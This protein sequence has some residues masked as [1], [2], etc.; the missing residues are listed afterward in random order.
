MAFVLKISNGNTTADFIDKLV[1]FNVTE[2]GL[3]L[4]QPKAKGIDSSPL[5]GYHGK[6]FSYVEYSNRKVSL[7]FTAYGT[8]Y[9]A[10]MDNLNTVSKLINEGNTGGLVDLEVAVQ[11][12]NSSYLRI[13]SGELKLPEQL[14]SMSGAHWTE[15]DTYVLHN[16]V[17]TVDTAPFF[18]DY[19]SY[20]KE[21]DVSRLVTT[22]I[23]NGDVISIND[24]D[25]DV[26]TETVLE[27]VGK[28][29]N[30]TQKIYI[31]NGNF[32]YVTSLSAG[33]DGSVTEM[34]VDEDYT[35][36]VLVPFA[37]TID[38]EDL[39]VTDIEAGVWTIVRG[40]NA[41]SP[42]THSSA[43]TVTLNTLHHL[44]AD[45]SL[46]YCD[47]SN[48]RV[49]VV[50]SISINTN[51]TGYIV[52]EI[53][54]FT[55][56]SGNDDCKIRILS[57]TATGA[58]S[59]WEVK[60]GGSDYTASDTNV[61]VSNGVAT[62]DIDEITDVHERGTV[63]TVSVPGGSSGTGYVQDEDLA[64]NGGDGNLTL[65]ID[66]VGG[67]GEVLTVSILTDGA[68]YAVADGNTTTGGSGSSCE[69]NIDTITVNDS[70]T[71]DLN[72]NYTTLRVSGQGI[73]DLVTWTL[74]RE[75]VSVI[76]QRVRIVGKEAQTGSCWNASLNYRVKVG[77]I[78]DYDSSFI[79]MDKTDWKTPNNNTDAL[80]DFGSAVVPPSGSKES[81]PDVT[82]ILQAQ[83][84]PDDVYNASDDII[85]YDLDLDF[86]TLIPVG[87]G[88]R[89]INCGNVPFFILDKLVDDS[90]RTA[91][92]IQEFSSSFLGEVS[93]DGIMPPIRLMPSNA[94]NSLYFLC[95]DGGG[96]ASMA[97]TLDVEV[98]CV[99]NYL[100]LVD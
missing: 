47:I 9:S 84:K 86:I 77:Y 1:S 78:T 96:T 76:N 28:Y 95:E 57:V 4:G 27:F 88:F 37:V 69:I 49:G 30:G 51:G 25:G 12:S 10:L 20:T 56:G 11:D 94:G 16:C 3:K 82:L 48:L 31:G 2:G 61:A 74:D 67:S 7:N 43:A 32:S 33:I 55:G 99:G 15:G 6:E 40:H 58:I 17:L 81:S 89:Y 52:N 5:I 42:A 92:Y 79:E 38:S 64:V 87:Q 63:A 34:T 50:D 36:K 73:H 45:S 29:S 66:T 13:L 8:T 68:E 46:S 44:G 71:D 21:G 62:F 80:F 53:L 35:G 100:G 83:I 97:L 72:S 23:D 90:R 70:T 19:P 24:V 54:T 93:V 22:T 98:G 18:T 59:T 75:Y 14:F 41:T 65:N 85:T 26:I 60:D 91:P 39:Q